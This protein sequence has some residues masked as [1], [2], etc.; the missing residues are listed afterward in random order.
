MQGWILEGV[1]N[2]LDKLAVWYHSD[3][4]TSDLKEMAQI[5]LRIILGY[6][7]QEDVQV[8]AVA[9]VK[10][11]SLLQTMPIRKEEA[12]F[13][14]GKLDVPLTRSIRCKTEI[15]SYLMP[16]VRT[17][18][19]QC[20]QLLELQYQLPSLPPTNG[21]PTFFEDFQHFCV[22][23]EW[24]LFLEKQVLK[25]MTQYE[26]DTFDRSH[27]QM[28]SFW[29]SCYDSLMSSS[30]RR[31]HE[32]GESRSKFEELIL[33]PYMKRVRFENA[34]YSNVLKQINSHHNT[35]LR[36][37]QS[38]R[39]LFTCP[40]GAWAECDRVPLVL[41]Y[42]PISI[43]IQKIISHHFHHIQRDATTRHVFPSP[44][45]SAFHRNHSLRDTLVQSSFI[46]NKPP[47]P[48]GTFLCNR[49]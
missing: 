9:C 1:I 2:L 27:N 38:L 20:Y 8:C 24:R 32:R 41:N 37:W 33:E 35:V 42:H 16:I 4:E 19:D 45:L 47:Q 31:E 10:L 44:P 34:R 3:N 36:Q 29:N 7:V 43:H 13:L 25:A 12:C 28:S 11:H 21:S 23:S 15:F 30:L 40:R 48:L 5:G 46:P 39:R 49:Q 22:T 26:H 6:I 14:L 18:M 17:L